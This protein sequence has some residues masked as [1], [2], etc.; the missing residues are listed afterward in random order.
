MICT[1][2]TDEEAASIICH[3]NCNCFQSMIMIG[4]ILLSTVGG[5]GD[6]LG[7]DRSL[8]RDERHEAS[9]NHQTTRQNRKYVLFIGLC[10]FL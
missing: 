2:K 1:G 10:S 8:Q 7:G 4:G 3:I 9:S 5:R 6:V